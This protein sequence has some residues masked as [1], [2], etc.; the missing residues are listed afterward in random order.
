MRLGFSIHR[1][2]QENKTVDKGKRR[3][4]AVVVVVA[5]DVATSLPRRPSAYH[6]RLDSCAVLS[7]PKVAE[8]MPRPGG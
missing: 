8:P 3:L 7:S 6:G 4:R 5:G 1:S 2:V